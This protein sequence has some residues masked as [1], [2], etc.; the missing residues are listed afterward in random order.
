MLLVTPAL[1]LLDAP[2]DARAQLTGLARELVRLEVDLIL[3]RGTPQAL[4]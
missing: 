4:E 2:F 3:T 1:A